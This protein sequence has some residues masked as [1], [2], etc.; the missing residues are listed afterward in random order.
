MAT[1]RASSPDRRVHPRFAA[2]ELRGLHTARVKY[3]REIS[4]INLSAGGVWFETTGPLTPES[5]IVLE[6]LGP[7]N[8]VLVPSRVLRCQRPPA[9]ERGARARGACAFKRL[10]RLK[11]LVT[12]TTRPFDAELS[13]EDSGSWHEVVGKYRDGRLVQGYTS[14]FSPLKSYLH[15]SPAPSAKQAQWVSMNELDA[16]FFLQD[17]APADGA[18]AVMA[19]ESGTP[20]GRKVALVLPSGEELVGSTLNYRRDRN[21]FFIHPSDSD[22]GVARVFV[23]QSGIRSVRF[24]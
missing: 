1:N 8:T 5:T 16:I 3:G 20:Y 17:P 6:F 14:D 24:L 11:E 19:R 12:G 15:V 2:N 22:F 21:G 18:D 7:A 23:T 4:V 10:L 13:I 9:V